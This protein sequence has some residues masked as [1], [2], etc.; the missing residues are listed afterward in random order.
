MNKKLTLSIEETVID[1]AKKYA[2][3]RKRSLSDIVENYLKVIGQSELSSDYEAPITNSLRGAFKTAE[4]FEYKDAL[5]K[6]LSNKYMEN[7]IR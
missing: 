7:S 4:Q 2:Q 1:N 6:G 5:A 3:E